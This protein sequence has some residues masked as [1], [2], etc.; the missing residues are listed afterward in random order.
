MGWRVAPRPYPLSPIPYRLHRVPP[1]PSNERTN[2]MALALPLR[3]PH[4]A[5][6]ARAD[7][8]AYSAVRPVALPAL[9]GLRFLAAAVVVAVHFSPIS[10]L[11]G[12]DAGGAAVTLFF[13]LSG[14]ILTY[15][16][17]PGRVRV[18][19]FYVARLA[20]IYPAYLVGLG[21]AAALLSTGT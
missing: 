13:L 19:E 8:P 21:L 15:T 14:F 5:R 16:A 11:N 6:A 3:Y 9:T 12:S 2:H 20:R 17:R 18:R 10:W 7:A 4:T 1:R